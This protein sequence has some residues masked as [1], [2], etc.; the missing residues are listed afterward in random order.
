M[1]KLIIIR[2]VVGVFIIAVVIALLGQGAVT[3]FFMSIICTVGISLIIWLP[4]AYVLGAAALWLLGMRITVDRGP[5]QKGGERKKAPP[6][7]SR[8]IQAIVKFIK[9]AREQNMPGEKITAFLR[10]QGW[11]EKDITEAFSV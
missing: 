1:T 7:P 10:D 8:D 3:F 9:Q 11:G 4:L 2:C 6:E 5:G